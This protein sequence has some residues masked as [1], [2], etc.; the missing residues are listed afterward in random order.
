VLK[1]LQTARV[2]GTAQVVKLL[3]KSMA[4][5]SNPSTA[6]KIIMYINDKNVMDGKN[7]KHDSSRSLGQGG[8]GAHLSHAMRLCSLLEPTTACCDKEHFPELQLTFLALF[9]GRKI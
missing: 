6:G 8:V 1:T 5:S 9:A 2:G 3:S 4:L 7:R